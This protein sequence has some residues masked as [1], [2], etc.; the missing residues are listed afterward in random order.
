MLL[1]TA[2]AVTLHSWSGQTDMLIGS[3]SGG[4]EHPELERLIGYFL[5]VLVIRGDLRG[6][7]P[8]REALHR[9]RESLVDA[10]SHD[11]LPF[12]RLVQ[13]LPV[14][15]DLGRSPLFQVTF[16]IEPL[17][18]AVGPE[19]DLSEMDTGETVSKFDLSIELEHRS[20][21][22]RGRAIYSSDLFEAST[23][24]ELVSDY[25]MVLRSVVSDAGQT[26]QQL[27]GFGLERRAQRKAH[28]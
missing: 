15:R 2:F 16:S 25:T 5:R 26:L 21:C 20:D 1:L 6:N 14:A 11:A 4:R 27:T 19:W 22:I 3:V 9:I 12:Q 28:P 18:P 17:M 7:P 10:L 13:A 24:S 23:I 8:F